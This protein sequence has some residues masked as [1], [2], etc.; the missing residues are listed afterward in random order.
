MK[1]VEIDGRKFNLKTRKEVTY[2]A[3]KE[4]EDLKEEAATAMM[5]NKVIAELWLTKGA[6]NNGAGITEEKLMANLA[7]SD[8]HKGLSNARKAALPPEVEAIM[9]SASLSRDEV[10]DLPKA[11]VDELSIVANEALGGLPNFIKP[12]MTDTT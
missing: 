6:D 5:P 2:G 7:E 4:V 10:F 1:K 8:L 11:V 9:L 3:F 12:S